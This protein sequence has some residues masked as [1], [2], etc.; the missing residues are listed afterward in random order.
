MRC[1]DC[2]RPSLPSAVSSRPE[3]P[4]TVDREG[5]GT[6]SLGESGASYGTQTLDANIQNKKDK[7]TIIAALE[8]KQFKAIKTC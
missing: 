2:L 4:P 8:P 6:S 3:I 7:K 5:A 1:F